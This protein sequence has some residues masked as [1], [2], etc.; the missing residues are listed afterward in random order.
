MVQEKFKIVICRLSGMMTL[1]VDGPLDKQS[2]MQ[3]QFTKDTLFYCRNA[4]LTPRKG[5]LDEDKLDDKFGSKLEKQ[6]RS[7]VG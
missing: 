7:G 1:L 5:D 6:L 4:M 2:T 3:E